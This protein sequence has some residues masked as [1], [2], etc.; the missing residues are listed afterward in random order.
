MDIPRDSDIILKVTL[1]DSNTSLIEAIERFKPDIS[2]LLLKHPASLAALLQSGGDVNRFTAS[3][4][5]R[6][7]ELM[8]REV[9]LRRLEWTWTMS[10]FQWDAIILF[11]ELLF[12]SAV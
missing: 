2:I 12:N 1:G 7:G 5:T 3:K 8:P 9:I 4:K 11:E 6:P 10:A